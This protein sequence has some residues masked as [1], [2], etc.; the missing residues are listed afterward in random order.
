MK[1]TGWMGRTIRY[2][3]SYTVETALVLSV[4][5]LSL[6]TVIKTAYR[7]HDITAGNMVLEEMLE[8]LRYSR[9]EEDMGPE[10]V[11][12]GERKANPALGSGPVRIRLE[13]NGR[14][15]SGRVIMDGWEQEMK[16]RLFEPG[17]T[18][19]R[20]RALRE[21]GEKFREFED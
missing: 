16:I 6:G 9:G 1:R 7:R 12:E 17:R 4:V 14:R 2:E 3:A 20:Y 11:R 19:R 21:L 8:K 18:M 13:K 5:F 15:A 10:L